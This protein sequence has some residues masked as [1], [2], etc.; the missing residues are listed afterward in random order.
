[1]SLSMA[2]SSTTSSLRGES[3][4]AGRRDRRPTAPDQ[5]DRARQAPDH[6]GHRPRPARSLGTSERFWLNLHSRYDL[7]IEKDHLRRRPDRRRQVPPR[8]R[9]PLQDRARRPQSLGPRVPASRTVY[10]RVAAPGVPG[11][12]VIAGPGLGSISRSCLPGVPAPLE[13]FAGSPP[14]DDRLVNPDRS[15]T[16]G[17]VDVQ[18][19]LTRWQT[20]L[21]RPDAAPQGPGVDQGASESPRRAHRW[22]A[23]GRARLVLR[24]GLTAAG[25]VRRRRARRGC[26]PR[27]VPGRRG[28]ARRGRVRRDGPRWSR[29]V[30]RERF[31][32]RRRRRRSERR[33]RPARPG[34][35]RNAVA[36]L[37][38]VRPAATSRCRTNVLLGGQPHLRVH[39]LEAVPQV[40][41]HI[42]RGHVE[43]RRQAEVDQHPP[44]R[45][46][47]AARTA[48]RGSAYCRDE[49]AGLLMT[50]PW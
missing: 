2:G 22:A 50:H 34:A 9:R 10:D 27:R 29:G 40:G 18:D 13:R 20:P 42:E 31:G 37:V 1:M 26:G 47:R 46:R 7:E 8:L 41:E 43:V 12:G 33:R 5:R 39:R 38:S 23:A 45:R 3:Q 36:A 14:A 11:A 21:G 28:R 19:D 44:R 48:S 35:L 16:R 24:R 25:G 6:R 30:G 4:P 17:S 15:K 32:G 49:V